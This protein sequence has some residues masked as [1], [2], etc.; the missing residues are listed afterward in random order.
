[1]PGALREM[2]GLLLSFSPWAGRLPHGQGARGALDKAECSGAP[3]KM[4]PPSS[5]PTPVPDESNART[6]S[7]VGRQRDQI[8]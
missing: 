6:P 3:Q 7:S 2:A 1:M 4:P 5:P 8:S